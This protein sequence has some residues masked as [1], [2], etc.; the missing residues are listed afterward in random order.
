MCAA[1]NKGLVTTSKAALAANK[2]L[3]MKN[4]LLLS[5]ALGVSG[6]AEE[7]KKP[8][9]LTERFSYSVGMQIG[10]DFGTKEMKLDFEQFLAGVKAAYEGKNTLISKEEA[11]KVLNEAW[12]D[13]QAREK[14]KREAIGSKAKEE[15]ADYLAANQKK[16]GVKKT[17]SGLQYRIIKPG[18]GNSPKA[19]DRAAVHYRGWTLDGKEFDS[20]YS[21]NKTSTFAV[22]RVIPGWTET[23]TMMKPGG[24]WEIVVPQELAYGSRGKGLKIPPYSTLR[25]EIELISFEGTGQS[26][27]PARKPVTSNVVRIPSSN[28]IKKGAKPEVLTKD[29]VEKL[30][31]DK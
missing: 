5:L 12:Q 25:F 29:Q 13:Y 11:S 21:R 22:N 18:K 19:T 10:S 28:E 27:V 4:I 6:V 7:L 23:L 17:A 3:N 2:N 30:K 16:P 8:T 9:T 26:A 1:Q 31:K 20:S 14:A 24:K 15:G